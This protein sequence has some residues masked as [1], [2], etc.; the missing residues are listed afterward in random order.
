MDTT[1]TGDS[2]IGAF[3]YK[4][5]EN[6]KPLLTYQDVEYFEFLTFS[7]A[8]EAYTTTTEGA[9]SAMA[10]MEEIKQFISTL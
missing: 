9:L 5:L 6:E 1:G 4:A 2:F 7:N 8:Y 10:N 3:L